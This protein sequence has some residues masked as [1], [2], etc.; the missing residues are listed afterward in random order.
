MNDDGDFLLLSGIEHFAFCRR[1]WA[2]IHVEQQWQ[3]NFLTQEGHYLHER[4]HDAGFTEK[5]GSVLL[6]RG[7]PVRSESLRVTGSC[8]MVE[9]DA[10]ENGVPIQGRE[11]RWR[12]YPVEYKRGKPDLAGGAAMQLCAEAMCLEEMFVTDIPEGAVYCASEHRRIVIELTPELR[13]KVRSALEEMHNYF[14]RGYTPK[15]KMK[16]ACKSCSMLDIC[17]PDFQ[18]AGSAKMYMERLIREE[19]E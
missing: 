12:L 6:S 5:R 3:E 16:S 2:L 17:R 8:D 7:M 14:S 18:S 10:S 4:V 11:G 19:G 1:Q 15:C 13:D 9:M